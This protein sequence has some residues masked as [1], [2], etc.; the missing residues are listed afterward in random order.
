M[1]DTQT[2]KCISQRIRWPCSI[3]HYVQY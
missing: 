3:C 2:L 1:I